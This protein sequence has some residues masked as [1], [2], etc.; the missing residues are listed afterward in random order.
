VYWSEWHNDPPYCHDP[1]NN[2]GQW[3]GPSPGCGP[4]GGFDGGYGPS[5]GEYYE[6]TPDGGTT[7]APEEVSAQRRPVK[8]GA[9]YA[10]RNPATRT[11]VAPGARP[12]YAG[13]QQ[14]QP[15]PSRTATRPPV[16]RAPVG[17]NNAQARPI[18]W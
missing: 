7:S 6:S 18:M 2:C 4:Q 14:A 10:Q 16:N 3:I 11:Q 17:T 9:P 12:A 5:G 15:A 13:Q 1:C 8:P